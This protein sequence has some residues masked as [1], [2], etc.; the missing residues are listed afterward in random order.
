[1]PVKTTSNTVQY[2]GDG[3]QTTFPFTFPISVKGD[4]VVKKRVTATGVITTQVL[5]TH[6]TVTKS[7]VNFDNGGNV[8]MIAAPAGTD[9]LIVTRATTQ[10]QDTDLI[11]GGPHDSEAYENMVDKLA[12]QVQELQAQVDRCI[13]IPDTDAEGLNVE[14]PSSIER[15]SQYIGMDAAGKAIVAAT[16]ASYGAATPFIQTLLDDADAETARNTLELQ[17]ALDTYFKAQGAGVTSIFEK[18]ALRDTGIHI[19]SAGY[20]SSG[21]QVI[22]GIPFKPSVVLF[23]CG[24][25]AGNADNQSWGF[26]NGDEHRC[27]YRGEGGTLFNRV[28]AK[29]IYI[30]SGVG[31]MIEGYVS[32]IGANNFTITWTVTGARGASYVYLCLP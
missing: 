29:S 1:M 22:G 31:N 14:L 32:A 18:L 30:R 15:A 2:T 4:L 13:K 9:T 11:Y 6:Y 27:I 21:D 16:F 24:D 10:T 25:D 8:E 17:G 23:F 12:R 3:V 28:A 5:T 7:G 19:G 26:D 20:N